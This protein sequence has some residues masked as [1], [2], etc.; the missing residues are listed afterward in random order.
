[1]GMSFESRTI[2]CSTVM[3]RPPTYNS[4]KTLKLGVYNVL[5]EPKRA[6]IE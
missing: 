3:F 2:G 5:W 1:M 6:R 4:F